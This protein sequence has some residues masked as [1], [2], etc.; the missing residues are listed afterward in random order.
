[1][2]D[3]ILIIIRWQMKKIPTSETLSH[4]EN[5]EVLILDITEDKKFSMRK[6]CLIII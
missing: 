6:Y 5:Q 3:R 1:M 4:E 2:L